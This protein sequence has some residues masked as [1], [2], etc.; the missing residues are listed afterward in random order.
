[1]LSFK[2]NTNI[3]IQTHRQ[4]VSDE[5]INPS[6]DPVQSKQQEQSKDM[7]IPEHLQC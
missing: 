2:H 7:S 6:P 4:H 1:M 5:L 3:L